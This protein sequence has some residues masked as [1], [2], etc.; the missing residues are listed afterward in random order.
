MHTDSETITLDADQIEA[1]FLDLEDQAKDQDADALNA[2]M[3]V[4]CGPLMPG[5]AASAPA[6]EQWLATERAR[7]ADIAA[8][9]G[10]RFMALAEADAGI[11]AQSAAEN[12]LTIDPYN[13]VALRV[14][15][16]HLAA[17]GRVGRALSV[18]GEF[19][20]RLDVDLGV[21]PTQSTREFRDAIGRGDFP[22]PAPVEGTGVSAGVARSPFY[23]K[24]S[25]FGLGTL[26]IALVAAVL[27][28]QW[29]VDGRRSVELQGPRLLILPLTAVDGQPADPTFAGLMDDL[30][31]E[32]S[33]ASQLALMSKE[34]ALARSEWTAA[35]A[36]ALG[37]THILRGSVRMDENAAILILRLMET[38]E[39]LEIWSHRLVADP[40]LL[41]FRRQALDDIADSLRVKLAG[42]DATA[43]EFTDDAVAFEHYL[44]ALS[45]FHRA[46]PKQHRIAIENFESALARDRTF[47]LA[48]S[49]LAQSHFRTAFGAQ[50]F[51][52]AVDVHWTEGFLLAMKLAL[53]DPALEGESAALN[54]RS[55]L[56][57]HRRDV[58]GAVQTARAALAAS[59]GDYQTRLTLARA[60]IF[61]GESEAAANEI[62]TGLALNPM[63]PA[64]SLFL[65]A[66]A[67]FGAGDIVAADEL[68]GRVV[69]LDEPVEPE[70]YALA[71]S[72]KALA[73]DK[74]AAGK[75]LQDYAQEVEARP[76]RLW[77]ATLAASSNP[78]ALTWDRPS[79][80]S[81][82]ARF[83]FQDTASVDRLARGL[84]VAGIGG[85][86]LGYYTATENERLPGAEIRA[87]LFGARAEGPSPFGDG[88][89]WS[90][91]RTE[92]GSM[93][94]S[95]PLGPAPQA[96][97]AKSYIWKDQLCDQWTYEGNDI[98]I[99]GTLY[100]L[101]K[102]SVLPGSFLLANELGYFPFSISAD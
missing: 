71:A 32:L 16:R 79:L 101:A 98:E 82:I 49:S 80:A 35:E 86:S 23:L 8:D 78:R 24:Q 7:L 20:Q 57:L 29:G 44:A 13:E 95:T 96:R 5:F 40:N 4:Y 62:K 87:L 15:M 77:R 76:R 94:Q 50:G 52:D 65:S 18:F 91:V 3:A 17:N 73:Q 11:D 93:F 1:D 64:N 26:V 19:E 90:Q 89:S 92:D 12:L 75:F 83:P 81:V 58:D 30:S 10:L 53:A 51:A 56:A 70:F 68:V 61:A 55:Q 39:D 41:A 102:S 99:C 59:P 33:R 88:A 34:T 67:A 60:L 85:K 74:T 21:V 2:A 9:T 66:L 84:I 42:D 6:F 63:R 31:V 46:T 72:T 45:A 97:E 27:L 25:Q 37:V 22:L 28:W 43:P 100:K 69:E 54:L 14:L 47:G 38:E 48:L 36:R